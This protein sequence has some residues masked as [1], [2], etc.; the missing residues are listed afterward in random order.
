MAPPERATWLRSNRRLARSI[1]RP[2]QRFLAIEAAG[3]LL[4][5]AAA[6]VALVWANS[7]WSASYV[8]LWHTDLT[9][10]VGGHV[11]AEDLRHWVNDGLMTLFFFV[12]GLEIKHE[13]ATGSSPRPR[14]A[15]VPDRRRAR[16]HGRAGRALPRRSTSAAT[17][18]GLGDPDGHRH[19]L[20]RRRARPARD[21]R[22]GQLKVLLLG[23]AIVDDIGAI[24]VIAVFYT[25][26]V[27]PAGSLAGGRRSWSPWSL[28]RPGAGAVPAGLRGARHRRVVRTSTSRASTPP[29]PVSPR[30]ARPAR[31]FLAE[32]DADRI[33]DEL[34]ADTDVDA[35]EVR[36]SLPAPR[37]GP[38]DRAAQD[39]LH[40]WTSY[41]DRA[42]F[43]LANAVASPDSARRLV[44]PADE[45]VCVTSTRHLVA[46]GAWYHDFTQTTDAEVLELLQR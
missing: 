7:P 24:L 26:G 16:R 28:L 31:P 12:I 38:G 27:E 34:S 35:A 21:R 3:G 19:R 33:A 30:P 4:L 11:I 17:A 45:V 44:P 14:D 15:A 1:G 9:F 8:D 20:R 32:V 37:V 6:V 13:L 10:D 25:D 39:L 18:R 40:P 23:L 5:V 43:A 36:D 42:L 22:A 2:I 46:V 29:S 41:L